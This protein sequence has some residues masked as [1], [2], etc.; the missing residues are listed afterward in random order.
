MTDSENLTPPLSQDTF[1]ELWNHVANDGEFTAIMQHSNQAEYSY[2][3][4]DDEVEMQLRR[5]EFTGPTLHQQLL[6]NPMDDNMIV[7][8]SQS[9]VP[10]VSVPSHIPSNTPYS[11]EYNFEV[12]FS[13]AENTK[14]A[15]WTFSVETNKLY[16][17]PLTPC[18]VLFKTALP[19]PA[20]SLIRAMAIYLKPEHVQDIVKRCPNHANASENNVHP[21]PHHLVR[22]DNPHAQYHDDPV[23][24]RHSVIVPIEAPQAG[25]SDVTNL[26]QFMCYNSCVGG[27]NRR[28]IQLVFT[29]ENDG[30]VLGRRPVSVRVCACPSRDRK[31]EEKGVHEKRPSKLAK[32]SSQT[33]EFTIAKRP[34]L[35]ADD[36]MFM[37]QVR[38]RENYEILRRLQKSLEL[39]QMVPQAQVQQYEAQQAQLQKQGRSAVS[40]KAGKKKQQARPAP[41]MSA[42]ADPESA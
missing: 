7:A 39:A 21:A 12:L 8:P 4:A 34:E 35:H 17:K 33:T 2:S 36:E 40:M 31:G 3:N 25:A 27:L 6:S 22:C 13:P 1:H 38:G 41:I 16:V 37:L 14:R 11:G 26:Y 30:K 23:T 24:S 28:P 15:V 20:G 10:P 32:V 5:Y 29:L 19:P 9:H 18:P 42:K